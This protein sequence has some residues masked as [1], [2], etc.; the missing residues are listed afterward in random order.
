MSSH[1]MFTIDD[2]KMFVDTYIIERIKEKAREI[3]DLRK[4]MG[5]NG[6]E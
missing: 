2:Y 1:H 6:K 4:K 3:Q 5:E